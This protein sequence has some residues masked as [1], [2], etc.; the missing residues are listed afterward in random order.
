MTKIVFFD[1]DGTLFDSQ[2]KIPQS[3]K[4]SIAALQQQGIK[5]AIATGR[6]PFNVTAISEELEVDTVICYNGQYVMHEGEVIYRNPMPLGELKQLQALTDANNHALVYAGSET[7]AF[8]EV[9]NL[10]VLDALGSVNITYPKVIPNFTE[11]NDIYQMLVFA[12]QRYDTSYN[13]AFAN[14]K[15]VR[16]HEQSMDV[17]P[18]NGSKADG[19]QALLEKLAIP[20]ENTYAFGDGMNDYEMLQ[21]VGHGIAMGNGKEPL[22][23]VADYVTDHVDEDGIMKGLRHFKLI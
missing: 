17:I 15:F 4:N 8:D 14:Y 13:E 23:K 18:A 12:D 9:N 5:V 3:T 6:S 1:V 7:L 10:D 2:N 16:W 22:K 11:S 20:L 19:I 21:L